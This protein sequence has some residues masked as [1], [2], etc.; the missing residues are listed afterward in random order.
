MSG[1][2]G[3][4]RRGDPPPRRGAGG[5]LR[6]GDAG[7][8][9]PHRGRRAGNRR[10]PRR[11]PRPRARR[12]PAPRRRPGERE[13]RLRRSP[14]CRSR[15]RTSCTCA[16][17]PTTCGS[18]IL[19]GYRPPFAATAVARLEAAGAIVV[20]KTN[21]DEFAMGSSTENSAYKADPQPLGP[22]RASP[23]APRAA[24]P[25]RSPRG[26]R[27]S[28]SAPTPAARSAS[29]RPSAASSASSPPTAASAATASSPSP[30]RSTRSAPSPARS[31]TWPSPPPRSSAATR[32]TP[33]APTEPVPDFAA[34][35]A[36]RRWRPAR[37]RALGAS[38]RT[39]VEAETMAPLPRVARR[40][41]AQRARRLVDVA[42]P[43]LPHAIATYY[44]V[45]TAEASSNL[46]RYDGVRYGRRAP[47]EPRPRRRSTAR[48]ATPASGPR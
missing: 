27:R 34:A 6:G 24:R 13:R 9:R 29:P 12:R 23:A 7:P 25:P 28:R 31:R 40:P 37:R 18:R 48:R 46:A 16:G 11:R 22:S 33:R 35:L 15:S 2:A 14:A 44:L 41:R 32:S 19:E 10:L 17:L 30:P 42:L 43:H 4:D 1:L 21:M 45:A 8:P 39:G 20:G 3:A 26:W 38:S 5:L 36:R 47:G